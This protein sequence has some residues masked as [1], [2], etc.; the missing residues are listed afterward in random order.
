MGTTDEDEGS[1]AQSSSAVNGAR[2]KV[3]KEEANNAKT[4]S[5]NSSSLLDENIGVSSSEINN[6][7]LGGE[8]D[9]KSNTSEWQPPKRLIEEA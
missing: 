8:S 7:T 3:E 9:G 4:S 6:A 2:D 1:P 5:R